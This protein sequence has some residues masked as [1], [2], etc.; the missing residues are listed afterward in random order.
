LLD[1]NL[2]IHGT[3]SRPAALEWADLLM[4]D[5]NHNSS[6]RIRQAQRSLP[7]SNPEPRQLRA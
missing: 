1:L 5:E 6:V 2:R 7:A 4:A 3:L